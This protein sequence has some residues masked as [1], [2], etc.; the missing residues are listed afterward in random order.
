MPSLELNNWLF[1]EAALS[2][3]IGYLEVS[4]ALIVR[5]VPL[6]LLSLDKFL[7]TGV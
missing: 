1:R 5:L 2:A 3:A 6:L 4:E 7:E